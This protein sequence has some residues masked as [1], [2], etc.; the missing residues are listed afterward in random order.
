[1]T[2]LPVGLAASRGS[3]KAAGRAHWRGV[4]F[5]PR[6]ETGETTLLERTLIALLLTS[7][8]GVVSGCNTIAGAGKDIE[9]GGQTIRDA[10]KDV[11]RKM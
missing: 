3:A 10:A 4:T 7:L 9:R 1:L 6:T 11:Q 5:L 8:I 2:G